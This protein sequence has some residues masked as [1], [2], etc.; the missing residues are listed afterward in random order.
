MTDYSLDISQSTQILE[1]AGEGTGAS[2][3]VPPG[4]DQDFLRGRFVVCGSSLEGVT[5]NC[6]LVVWATG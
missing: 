2:P 6:F 5:F 4:K 1:S 3:Q